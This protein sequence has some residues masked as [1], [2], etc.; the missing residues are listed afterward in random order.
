MF[1]GAMK[2]I[3]FY[4]HFKGKYKNVN[5]GGNLMQELKPGAEKVAHVREQKMFIHGSLFISFSE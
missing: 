2:Q 5:E 4:C 1:L 3:P